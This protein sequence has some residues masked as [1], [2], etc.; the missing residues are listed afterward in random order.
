MIK[1]ICKECGEDQYTA[2]PYS[3]SDCIYCGGQCKKEEEE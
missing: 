2:D 3:D 1:Y